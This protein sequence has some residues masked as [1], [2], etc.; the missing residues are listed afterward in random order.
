MREII[1]SKRQDNGMTLSCLQISFEKKIT[2][3]F[4]PA[5]RIIPAY[6]YYYAG[7]KVQ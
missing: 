6:N 3:S 2:Y 4:D 1:R 7:N 5:S